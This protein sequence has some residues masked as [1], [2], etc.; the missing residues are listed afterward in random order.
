[1]WSLAWH[2]R[3]HVGL[4]VGQIAGPALLVAGR[5]GGT[6]EQ[7]APLDLALNCPDAVGDPG[8]RPALAFG[9]VPFFQLTGQL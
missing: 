1:L 8:R 6:L 4:V 3:G 9:V 5:A 7:I 2:D